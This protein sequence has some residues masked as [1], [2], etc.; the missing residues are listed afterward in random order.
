MCSLSDI[1]GQ[2]DAVRTLTDAYA[3]DR[4]PHGLI[5]AGPVGIG[6]FTTAQ[7]LAALFLCEKP[8]ASAPCEKCDGCRAFATGNHPDFHVI[9]KEMVRLYDKTGKSKA[10]T[11]SIDVIR[12]ELVQKAGRKPVMGTGKVFVIEQAD[13]MQTAA[14]NAMLKV[15][16]EPP[17]RTLIILLTDQPGGLIPTIR[18]RAQVIRFIPLPTD[19]VRTQLLKRGIDKDTAAS[20]ASLSEGSL[21]VALKWIEDGVIAASSELIDQLDTLLS[22]K[23]TAKIQDWFKKSAEAY[24]ERQLRR[25]ELSSKD[26]GTRDGISVYLRIAS[27]HF[28]R[29]LTQTDNPDRL[30]RIATA[31]DAL[32]Q[33]TNNLEANVSIPLSFQQ[34]CVALERA[35]AD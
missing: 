28:R 9:V 24:G 26:Q 19:L 14:Q 16:E 5:F 29:Q 21:G 30:E 7:A 8:K 6:K 18:S 12:H 17:G 35:L 27:E 15:L 20:A 25:D 10:I 13:Y 1:F 32:N 31:I 4:L 23:P 34:L 33:T 2:D 3:S 22:G 11:M